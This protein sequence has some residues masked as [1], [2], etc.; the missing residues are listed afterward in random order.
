MLEL[1]GHWVTVQLRA[2]KGSKALASFY[3]QTT[4]SKAYTICLQQ[5]KEGS[6][7]AIIFSCDV[8]LE[9]ANI[10]TISARRDNQFLSLDLL[11]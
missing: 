6:V 4:N 10:E 1:H 5:Q 8:Y 2:L 3:S 7:A 9:K 11:H